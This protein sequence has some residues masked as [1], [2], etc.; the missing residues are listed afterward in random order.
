MCLHLHGLL[1]PAVAPVCADLCALGSACCS[2]GQNLPLCGPCCV[3]SK[4]FDYTCL[5]CVR[6][7]S[8]CVQFSCRGPWEVE[9][10]SSGGPARG[11]DGAPEGRAELNNACPHQRPHNPCIVR[12]D[13]CAHHLR[14]MQ[15]SVEL[16][17]CC[18]CV[19]VLGKYGGPVTL[20]CGECK[21]RIARSGGLDGR[22]GRPGSPPCHP[23][24]QLIVTLARATAG[25]LAGGLYFF[26][27]F[28]CL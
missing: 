18:I 6:R 11:G 21:A 26:D 25:G 10:W 16:P 5:G 14:I 20:P 8:S 23:P 24:R 12:Q 28:A 2:E 15:G 13:A 1:P 27:A 22:Q 7:L 4:T 3:I 9:S 17:L 19:E